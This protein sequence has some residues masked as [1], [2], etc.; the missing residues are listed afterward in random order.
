MNSIKLFRLAESRM[1]FKPVITY[2]GRWKNENESKTDLKIDYANQDHSAGIAPEEDY[3][4][5][6]IEFV[7]DYKN[8]NKIE[9]WGE[10]VRHF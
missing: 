9:N 3:S 7:Q 1:F 4:P 5:Y 6:L 2:L 8:S 10:R